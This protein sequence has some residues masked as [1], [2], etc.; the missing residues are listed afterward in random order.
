[1]DGILNGDKSTS[2]NIINCPEESHADTPDGIPKPTWENI[3]ESPMINYVSANANLDS[4]NLSINNQLYA[5]RYEPHDEDDSDYC[6][7]EGSYYSH[8]SFDNE[9]ELMNND[10]EAYSFTNNSL[11]MKMNSKFENAICFKRALN[12]YAI[13]NEFDYFI[14]KSDPTRFTA[15]C[16]SIDCE[17]RI[18]ASI[19]QDGITFE[20]KKMMERHTCEG[21][22]DAISKGLDLGRRAILE[23]SVYLKG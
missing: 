22:A 6:P 1:M 15:R 2:D 3:V 9:Y 7:S 4:N 13:T 5:N 23:S 8:L 20:V 11:S 19:M 18:H 14:L 10:D 21:D 17:W 12:H 16:E